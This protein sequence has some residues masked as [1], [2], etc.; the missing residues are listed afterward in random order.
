MRKRRVVWALLLM[1]LASVL[2]P[3][4]AETGMDGGGFLEYRVSCSE[5]G[6]E[7]A[8]GYL[9]DDNIRTRFTMG[10]NT[11]LTAEWDGDAEGLLISWYDVKCYINLAFYDEKGNLLDSTDLSVS[12]YRTFFPAKG[13]RRA[14]V[15]VANKSSASICELRV[16]AP[17]Y[18]PPCVVRDEPVDLMLVLSGVSDELE[19]MGGL[20]PLYTREHGIRTAIVY[21]GKDFGYQ[22][23][24]AFRAWE[25][26]GIDVIPVFLQKDDQGATELKNMPFYWKEA[27]TETQLLLL[28]EQYRPK[29]L[30]TCDPSSNMLPVR[31]A[32]TGQL[33]EH[34]IRKNWNDRSM[35]VQKVYHLSDEGTTVVDYTER[36]VTYD[37]ATAKEA[38]EHAHAS[39]RSRESYRKQIPDT[40]RFRLILTKVGEDTAQNDLFEHIDTGTLLQFE[41]PEPTT[42][43]TEEPTAVPTPAETPTPAP[44]AAGTTAE[45]AAE[46]EQ[47]AE[48]PVKEAKKQ[49]GNVLNI[50]P[51]ASAG[52]CVLLAAIVRG[53]KPIV[54]ASLLAIAV[55][56]AILAVILM[57]AGNAQSSS[58]KQSASA[59]VQ[60]AATAVPPAVRESE[61]PE[62]TAEPTPEST[63]EP[64]PEPFAEF[65]RQE[66]EPEEVVVSDYEN[67]HWEYRSDILAVII[68]REITRERNNHPYCKYIAHVYMRNTN[69]FR[70]IVTWPHQ[71]QAMAAAAPW[72]LARANRAVL[73]VTGDNLND[74][75]VAFKGI[76]LRNGVLYSDGKGQDTM[77]IDDDLTMRIVHQQELSGRDLMDSGVLH[78]FSFGPVL[79]ENGKVNPD[80]DKHFVAGENPRCGVGMIEPGHFLVIVSDG[81][82]YKRAYGYKMS[83]F[84]QI[85]ADHGAQVAYNLDGGSSSGMVFMGE[86]INWH[87]G[88]PQRT[89]ADGLAWGYSELI[90]GPHDPI[91]RPG[92][93]SFY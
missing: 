77:V 30:V 34:M 69:S 73:A 20:L 52:V 51:F 84:A 37:S 9:S 48:T 17:G 49:R 40:G 29:V 12:D 47:A 7:N 5:A 58:E 87:S 26:L 68:D 85:F 15:T 82:D 39:Y 32:F 23:Q 25:A 67:G 43:P 78:S 4:A 80:A 81:R 16:C 74:A 27:N 10:A 1:L 83:E 24:E 91:K 19:L 41:M 11:T 72:R 53:R 8:Y 79:V 31:I 36:L 57:R 61:T 71:L 64:T 65:F 66:G 42:V 13:A 92:E 46:T 88:D 89:W 45:P 93:R 22:V 60:P 76:L 38:A 2:S 3:A 18:E 59:S 54:T 86:H 62:P 56:L 21:L 35:P 55:T 75:D 14:D 44:A 6:R 63:P 33:T 28:I 70:P 90:P 50:V